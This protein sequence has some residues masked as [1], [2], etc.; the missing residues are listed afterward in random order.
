MPADDQ[1]TNVL[2]VNTS[3]HGLH[4]TFCYFVLKYSVGRVCFSTQLIIT[5]LQMFVVFPLLI[6]SNCKGLCFQFST[7]AQWNPPLKNT[8]N[9]QKGVP[10]YP[11]KWVWRKGWPPQILFI[12]CKT[13]FG[14]T[15]LSTSRHTQALTHTNA[16]SI[17]NLQQ[18]IIN[19][20]SKR[21]LNKEKEGWPPQ[22]S[23][24]M[25]SREGWPPQMSSKDDL[26]K[27]PVK[28]P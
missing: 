25:V 16:Y 3:K 28:W 15:I 2:K 10:R 21:G 14:G 5:L 17:H 11:A 1:E 19:R 13:L 9:T 7:L 26:C 4:F 8:T 18:Q 20:D 24:K 12:Q 23:S 22:V 6:Y 27:Y